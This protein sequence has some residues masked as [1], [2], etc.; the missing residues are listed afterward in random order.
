MIDLVAYCL[1]LALVCIAAISDVRTGK[2]PNRLTYTA[3]LLGLVYWLIVSLVIGQTSIMVGCV[4]GLA[5]GL[6][7][8][9]LIYMLGGLG[10]GDV[11]LMA[12]VGA[13]SASWRVVLAST[14]YAMVL[15]MVFAIFIMIRKGL[16]KQ[17]LSN[18]TRIKRKKQDAMT[19]DAPPSPQVA[20]ALAVAFGVALAG[21][22]V[23]LDMPTPW[24]AFGP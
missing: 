1:L 4:V 3:V 20:Y 10:G 15:A 5:A 14:V 24:Q 17:T 11:K 13:L 7:P 9:A 12:A 21:A 8:F 22:E 6:L 19:D 23:M 16:V 2:V 18:L